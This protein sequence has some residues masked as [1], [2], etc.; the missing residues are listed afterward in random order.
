MLSS[1]PLE[2]QY[3]DRTRDHVSG[4]LSELDREIVRLVPPGGNWRDLPLAFESRRVQ[5]IRA[6]ADRGEGS[7]STYYGRLRWDRPSYTISTYISRPGNGCFIHPSEPRLISI[8]EAARLQTFPDSWSLSGTNRKR[9]MQIGNAVPPLLAFGVARAFGPGTVVD[10]FSGAGGLGLG[11]K[12]AGHSVALGIDSDADAARAHE[13]NFGSAATAV[14]DMF[15]SGQRKDTWRLARRA[16]GG[17]PDLLV[18]GP[19]CQGFS[20]AGSSIENDPRN[21]L[22]LHFLEGIDALKPK[23]VVME[24]VIA[25]AQR[26]G[27]RYLG[28]VRRRLQNLGYATEVHILHAESFGVPQL[29][30]R[31]F[32]IA[33][34]G[35]TPP[36]PRPLFPPSAP[37]F[38]DKQ[39]PPVYSGDPP[40]VFDAIS[41]LPASTTSS[42]DLEVVLNEPSSPLQRHLRGHLTA[43][44]YLDSRIERDNR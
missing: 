25:L 14:A 15:S 17:S 26:R 29:R 6:S 39:P 30:R 16:V 34:R 3:G 33:S 22:V 5:Q 8:R 21:E 18:G 23:H 12:M 2:G 27:E 37:A 24:N 1:E 9:A 13:M 11:F 40:S 19:P 31:M 44:E 36:A 41:D 28:E 35:E 43:M 32:L 20:T 4:T 38:K 42:A 10:L 7:R